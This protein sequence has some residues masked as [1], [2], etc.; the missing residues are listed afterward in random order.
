MKLSGLIIETS[1]VHS[2][3]SARP[4][5]IVKFVFLCDNDMRQSLYERERLLSL[6]Q[7]LLAHKN[8][9]GTD[10]QRPSLFIPHGLSPSCLEE[11]EERPS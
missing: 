1:P 10:G 2:T 9:G 4:L 6:W 3:K 7:A 5:S 8:R 11:E